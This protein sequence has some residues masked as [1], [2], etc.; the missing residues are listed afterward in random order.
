MSQPITLLAFFLFAL[1]VAAIAHEELEKDQRY[2]A[3]WG[4]RRYRR[5]RRGPTTR[6]TA[7]TETEMPMKLASDHC[8]VYAVNYGGFC[9]TAFDLC[10][11]G[12]VP[13]GWV[14]VKTD[15]DA[16]ANRA[17]GQQVDVGVISRYFAY[18]GTIAD[19][20]Q[21]WVEVGDDYEEEV[22]NDACTKILIRKAA[23]VITEEGAGVGGGTAAVEVS[24]GL[25]FQTCAGGVAPGAVA[26]LRRELNATRAG[27]AEARALVAAL[28]ASLGAAQRS[29]ADAVRA[30]AEQDRAEAREQR[31]IQRLAKQRLPSVLPFGVGAA[32]ATVSTTAGGCAGTSDTAALWMMLSAVGGATLALLTRVVIVDGGQK[33]TAEFAATGK[34]ATQATDAPDV[35]VGV[36]VHAPPVPVVCDVA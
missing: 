29:I 20:E 10:P 23:A 24:P 21:K 16:A 18:P 32:E 34:D 13:I 25:V 2:R 5:R 28:Q 7:A 12:S 14:Q 8:P 35:V 30:Q 19:F 31:A 11:G 22:V 4:R 3:R 6:P 9:H 36:P 33:G 17:E 26:A 27:R 1:V 15:N